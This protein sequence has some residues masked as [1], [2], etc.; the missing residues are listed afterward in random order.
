MLLEKQIYSRLN[1]PSSRESHL[2][3]IEISKDNLLHNISQFQNIIG[4]RNISVVLKSNAYGHGLVHVG[5]ALEK[6]GSVDSYCINSII[7]AHRLRSNNI[8]KPLI[9][10]GHVPKAGLTELQHLSKTTIFINSLAQAIDISSTIDFPLNVH[11]K[12]DTGMRR[13]GIMPTELNDT[14]ATLSDNIN[15]T[16]SGLVTHLADTDGEYTEPTRQQLSV[17][18]DVATRA[19]KLIPTLTIFHFA[20]TGGTDFINYAESNMVRLGIGMYG[21]DP[22]IN[23]SLDLRPALSL[24]TKI[25]NRKKLLA[26]ESIG[27]NFTHTAKSNREI[28]ILP[29][30]YEEGIS[31]SL[32]NIGHATINNRVAPI[33]GRVS[34]N[35]TAIDVTDMFPLPKLGDEVEIISNNI[36]AKNSAQAIANQCDTIPY[37]VLTS[38]SSNI[39]REIV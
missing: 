26:G 11:I 10:M 13:N 5:K 6:E 14:Y 20:A 33:V 22:I 25:V 3:R 15:I 39:R 7:E 27:Y 28:A 1:R 29:V 8:T 19:K 18:V 2:S 32:S 12:V 38:L 31:R 30:G 36:A 24:Y 16:I 23:R 34:M 35:L 9:I 21:F 37:E 17:W 4:K